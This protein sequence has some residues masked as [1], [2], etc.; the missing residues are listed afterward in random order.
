[1]RTHENLRGC[2]QRPVPSAP[3]RSPEALQPT[4]GAGEPLADLEKP[5]ASRDG[6]QLQQPSYFQATYSFY[7]L[8]IIRTFRK[9]I[10][11]GYNGT[12]RL[13]PSPR[14]LAPQFSE[15]SCMASA[16][17]GVVYWHELTSKLRATSGG[18]ITTSRVQQKSLSLSCERL[19]ALWRV[20]R[21][22]PTGKKF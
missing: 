15:R 3:K 12:C 10:R 9:M 5:K 18:G 2:R 4:A 8:I 13:M 1:M 21:C 6:P 17:R 19:E 7:I 16:E 22:V 14:F 20:D 11:F